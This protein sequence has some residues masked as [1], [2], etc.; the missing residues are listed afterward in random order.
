M[1]RVTRYVV[2]SAP[3]RSSGELDLAVDAFLARCRT[4]FR[5]ELIDI[6]IEPTIATDWRLVR[7]T[8]RNDRQARPADRGTVRALM[9]TTNVQIA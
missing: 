5:T 7:C 2:R 8:W 1:T 9:S 4:T 3:H 6:A